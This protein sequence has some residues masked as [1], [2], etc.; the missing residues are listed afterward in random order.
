[1]GWRGHDESGAVS[2]R[3]DGASRSAFSPAADMVQNTISASESAS[4]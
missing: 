1:M 3:R 2:R 4:A